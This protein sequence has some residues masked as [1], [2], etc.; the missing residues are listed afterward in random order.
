M[1]AHSQSTK[2]DR[3]SEHSKRRHSKHPS[4]WTA[5]HIN[6]KNPSNVFLYVKRKKGK[7]TAPLSVSPAQY[8]LKLQ[9]HNMSIKSLNIPSECPVVDKQQLQ[10]TYKLNDIQCQQ[11]EETIKMLWNIMQSEI[12]KCRMQQS[13]NT[14]TVYD[15]SAPTRSINKPVQPIAM[16]YGIK[17]LWISLYCI[18]IKLDHK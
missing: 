8:L 16:F 18:L 6:T 7:G 11:A 4:I 17:C 2:S 1:F 15:N 3:Y 5:T 14:N 13:C 12:N 9:Q 10:T